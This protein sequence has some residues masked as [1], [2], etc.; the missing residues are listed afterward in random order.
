[1]T[2]PKQEARNVLTSVANRS[3]TPT[4]IWIFEGS[5][6]SLHAAIFTSVHSLQAARIRLLL[7]WESVPEF[8]QTVILIRALF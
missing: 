4:Q 1:M 3:G 7:V 8:Q 5:R 6:F 2:Y